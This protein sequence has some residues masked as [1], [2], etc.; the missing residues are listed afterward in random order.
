MDHLR[1]QSQQ[2]PLSA[3]KLTLSE[4]SEIQ[5]VI[6]ETQLIDAITTP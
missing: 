2:R 6:H 4:W 5:S 1:L 3:K